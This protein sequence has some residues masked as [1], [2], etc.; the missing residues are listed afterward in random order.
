MNLKALEKFFQQIFT[1]YKNI[2]GVAYW[3]EAVFVN[4][5]NKIWKKQLLVKK[6][7][8]TKYMLYKRYTLLTDCSAFLY[9]LKFAFF[10]PARLPLNINSLPGTWARLIGSA[11]FPWELL[12]SKSWS[13]TP[14][15]LGPRPGVRGQRGL[16]M[17]GARVKGQREVGGDRFSSLP[18]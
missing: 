10:T 6:N 4:Y 18:F 5:F 11:P 3:A 9:L 13:V 8:L 7:R 2:I 14:I 17:S 16:H 1:Q 15:C 12:A